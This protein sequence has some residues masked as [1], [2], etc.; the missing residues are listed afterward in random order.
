MEIE[1]LPA[2]VRPP[3]LIDVVPGDILRFGRALHEVAAVE[4][5]TVVLLPVEL[6]ADRLDGTIDGKS[7]ALVCNKPVAH[8]HEHNDSLAHV[9]WD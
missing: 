9:A 4:K 5:D 8:T 3:Q 6:C 2:Y 7:R 1:Q